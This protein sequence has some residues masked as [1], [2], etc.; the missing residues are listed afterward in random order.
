MQVKA[1]IFD[2]DG[3][4]LDTESIARQIWMDEAARLGVPLDED[5]YCRL[6]GRT[7]PDIR[8]IVRDAFHGKA[9]ADAYID[10]CL[11]L[12]RERIQSP[13]PHRPGLVK[14]LDY[15]DS[16]GL[17]KGV[18][19]SSGRSM[20][21]VKLRSGGIE[22]RFDVVVTGNE[23]SKGKPDPEI[24]LT[25]A[26]RLGVSAVESLV[27]EDSPNGVLAAHAAGAKVIMVPDMLQPEAHIRA[28]A[29]AVL[30]SLA[31]VPEY[32]ERRGWVPDAVIV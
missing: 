29:D 5:L 19:T 25:V 4:M 30:E 20:V 16:R 17:L 7:H 12:Y 24:F 14:M 27:L 3:L 31:E 2:M 6:I 9:D 13:I 28:A 26:A 1:V 22:G 8:Q 32:I 15:C 23:V 21:D 11:N 10:G 18:G